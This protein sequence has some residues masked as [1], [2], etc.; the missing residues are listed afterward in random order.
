[1]AMLLMASPYLLTWGRLMSGPNSYAT[2]DP[3]Y[4]DLDRVLFLARDRARWSCLCRAAV[5]PPVRVPE[6]KRTPRSGGSSPLGGSSIFG[7]Q[8]T[9]KDGLP[10]TSLQKIQISQR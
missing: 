2:R 5:R 8:R 3:R 9:G 10:I 4:L 6:R 7:M 1:M